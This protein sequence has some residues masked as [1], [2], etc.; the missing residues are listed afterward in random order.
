M[1]ESLELA[2]GHLVE[3]SDGCEEGDVAVGEL[4][5]ESSF[6]LVHVFELFFVVFQGSDV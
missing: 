6:V 3:V 1:C 4:E 5:V 2:V